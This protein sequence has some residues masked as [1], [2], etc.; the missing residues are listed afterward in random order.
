[1]L[2][3]DVIFMIMMESRYATQ[4]IEL[5]RITENKVLR[6]L[7]CVK[8][9]RVYGIPLYAV[10]SSGVRT[11]DGVQIM[12]RGLYPELYTEDQNAKVF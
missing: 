1:L 11:L 8:E 6:N 5:K 10:Y 9:K 3:P 4:D 2:D 7:K 12:A